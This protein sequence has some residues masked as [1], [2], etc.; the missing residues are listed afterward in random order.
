MP[1]QLS[2][3][4]TKLKWHTVFLP[5]NGLRYDVPSDMIEDTKTSK[6]E[7]VVMREGMVSKAPGTTVFG[8]TDTKPLA[9]TVMGMFQY[10]KDDGT[11]FLVAL[12][13]QRAY[14]YNTTTLTFDDIT[15]GTKNLVVRVTVGVAYGSRNL[16]CR[17]TKG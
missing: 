6:C 4:K 3:P 11:D 17:V 14:K 10:F 5:I 9:G 12:T 13:T 16:V 1:Q 2:L 15:S 8:S 7:E